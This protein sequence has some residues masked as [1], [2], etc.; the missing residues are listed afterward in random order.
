MFRLRT[1]IKSDGG[2]FSGVW[3]SPDNLMEFGA[4][5]GADVLL[6][7]D[8]PEELVARFEILVDVYPGYEDPRPINPLSGIPR[9][10]GIGQSVWTA[11][12]PV[13][14][15]ETACSGPRIDHRGQQ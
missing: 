5:D 7:V 15:S 3:L 11:R 10:G 14:P 13:L 2:N 12:D 4:T 8:I 6:C 9:A 1:Y